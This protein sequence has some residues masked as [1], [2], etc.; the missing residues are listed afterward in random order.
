MVRPV[1]GRTNLLSERRLECLADTHGE[2]GLEDGEEDAVVGF[3]DLEVGFGGDVDFEE[4]DRVEAAFLAALFETGF[5]A[6]DEADLQVEIDTLFGEGESEETGDN[7][8]ADGGLLVAVPEGKVVELELQGLDTDVGEGADSGVGAL[9][10]G[11]DG[12][13]GDV[14]DEDVGR[15]EVEGRDVEVLENELNGLVLVLHPVNITYEMKFAIEE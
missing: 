13:V 5:G 9:L 8:G 14:T 6:G 10:G 4:L 7:L 15:E 2:D 3:A 11:V 1:Q 12:N